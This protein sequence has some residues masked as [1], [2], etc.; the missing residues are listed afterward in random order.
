MPSGPIPTVIGVP[1]VLVAV[2]IGITVPGE[3][4]PTT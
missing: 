2:L 4:K 3:P 1:D